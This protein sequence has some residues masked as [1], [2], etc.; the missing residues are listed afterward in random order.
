MI[1]YMKTAVVW[2]SLDFIPRAVDVVDTWALVAGY[3]YSNIMK[4]SYSVLG[5]LINLASLPNSSCIILVDETSY[6]IPREL[7]SYND[8]YEISVAIRGRKI[9]VGIHR[10]NLVVVLENNNNSLRITRNHTISYQDSS[11][12]GRRVDWADEKTIAVLLY[13]SPQSAWSKSQVFFYDESSVSSSLPLYT[14]P[15]NQQILGSRLSNPYFARFMITAGGNM[16]ILTEEHADILI[17]PIAS[18]GTVS[19]WMDTSALVYVFYYK[20][21]PCIGGTFKSVSSLGP[22]QICPPRTR[23]PGESSNTSLACIPCSDKSTSFCPLASLAEIDRSTVPSYSQATAYPESP[24]TTDIEDLLLE[25]TFKIT[26][27]SSCL[28]ISPLFWASIVSGLSLLIWI[29]MFMSRNS[30]WRGY[31]KYREFAKNFFKHA[32]LIGEGERWAGGLAT[33]TVIV[34]VAFSYWFL[35]SFIARYPIEEVSKPVSFSCDKSLVNA[36][37]STGLEL[38][39]L[40]KSEDVRTIFTMLDEQKFQLTIDFINTG[41]TCNDIAAQQNLL[42]TKYIPLSKRCIQSKLNA[43][44]SITLT[45]PNHY[46]TVQINL[47]GPFWIGGF[48]L[49]FFGEGRKNMSNTLRQLDFCQFYAN[50]NQAISRSTVIPIVF[51]K[52]INMTKALNINDPVKYSGLWIPTFGSITLSD[53]AYYTDFGNYLRYTLS[54]TIIEITLN[55]S[56]YYIKNIQEP[57]VRRGQ[58]ICNGLLFTFLCI[59]IFAFAF[60]LIKLVILPLLQQADTIWKEY[61]HR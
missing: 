27:D 20:P 52:N 30:S 58:L 33:F 6:L 11:S 5:C 42:V 57:I 1:E 38:V 43:T 15:N 28:A 24:E 46:A 56:P 54:L 60:L 26:S 12:F 9:L 55:E 3:G 61:C 44:T 49:C 18:P 45:F 13:S 47:T 36:R 53:E 40:P 2:P 16:V 59:E 32:D 21:Q 31:A 51:V 35:A 25:N 29:V 34:L 39:S 8:L 14:F 17:I 50:G 7:K 48:R 23:N 4:K 10:F 22:C 37:F 41:F 19:I